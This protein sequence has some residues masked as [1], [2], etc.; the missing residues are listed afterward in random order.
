MADEQL[1]RIEDKLDRYQDRVEAKIAD[2]MQTMMDLG[3]QV[4]D[5]SRRITALEERNARDDEDAERA[6]DRWLERFWD[7]VKG[8]LVGAAAACI[9]WLVAHWPGPRP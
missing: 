5:A 2:F 9:G 6:R 3:Y 8:P 1:Q 4:R 7:L